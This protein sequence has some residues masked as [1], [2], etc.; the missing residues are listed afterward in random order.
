MID[1]SR[2]GLAFKFLKAL[3]YKIFLGGAFRLNDRI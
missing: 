3:M 1:K 2:L